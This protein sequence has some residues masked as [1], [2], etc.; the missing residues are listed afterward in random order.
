MQTTLQASFQLNVSTFSRN[1]FG[2]AQYQRGLIATSITYLLDITLEY[3]S[4]LSPDQEQ[5]AH[6][7]AQNY[8]YNYLTREESKF[9]NAV[10]VDN[11]DAFLRNMIPPHNYGI[12]NEILQGTVTAVFTLDIAPPVS[13]LNFPFIVHRNEREMQKDLL[14]MFTTYFNTNMSNLSVRVGTATFN[15]VKSVQVSE[16]HR[17]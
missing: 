13:R 3:P 4:D 7:T 8:I 15:P 12:L 6:A 10:V 11:D 17:D 14:Q 2:I 1:S 5:L 9:A 16:H